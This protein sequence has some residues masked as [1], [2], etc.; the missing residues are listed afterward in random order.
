M[1]LYRDAVEQASAASRAR[2]DE[3]AAVERAEKARDRAEQRARM[4]QHAFRMAQ[5]QRELS[6]GRLDRAL[7]LFDQ[8]APGQCGWEHHHLWLQIGQ[9]VQELEKKQLDGAKPESIR[10]S[11]DGLLLAAGFQNKMICL[12]QANTGRL[13]HALQGREPFV[14]SVDLSPDGRWLASAAGEE[15]VAPKGTNEVLLW[16]VK[17]GERRRELTGHQG[18][19]MVVRFAPDGSWLASHGADGKVHVWEVPSGKRLR[20]FDAPGVVECLAVHPEGNLLAYGSKQQVFLRHAQT[21]EVTHT[22][23]GFSGVINSLAFS[24]D[25]KLLACADLSSGLVH[26]HDVA[27]GKRLRSLGD[28][29]GEAACVAFAPGKRPLLAFGHTGREQHHPCRSVVEQDRPDSGQRLVRRRR[30]LL[31]PR[32]RSARFLLHERHRHRVSG[33][34]EGDEMASIPGRSQNG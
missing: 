32:G 15:N 17:T 14:W 1:S 4:S 9:G 5:M 8:C 21:G 34:Q 12:W 20:T 11:R 28:G 22:L 13:L 25:G 29:G 16:N 26:I 31:Q 10:F 33:R 24:G 23:T 2:D 18:T 3:R 30:R 7:K 19:V 27:T 6:A